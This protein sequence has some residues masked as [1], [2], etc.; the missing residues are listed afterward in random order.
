MF[1]ITPCDVTKPKVPV[2]INHSDLYSKTCLKRPLKNRQTK[3]LVTNGSLMK[4][5]SVA[6]LSLEH[7][8]IVLTCIKR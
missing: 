8:A 3:I 2:W 6:E 4:I 1:T 5:E 7:S